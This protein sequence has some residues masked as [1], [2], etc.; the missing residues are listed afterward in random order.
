MIWRV[1]VD[2]GGT[3]TDVCLFEEGSG[4]VE[5]W[6]V[7]STPDDPSR[8]I[9]RGI[10]EAIERIGVSASEIG[11]LGH[12]TT[13]ATN[14]L[15]QHR[16]ASTGLITTDGFRD[17]LEI[18]R[19]KR[20]EL[21]DLQA[22]KP[23][24]LIS[25]DLRLQ[26]P[27]R[28]RHDGT[29]E[30]PLDEEAMRCAAR[31]LKAAG[32]KAVVVCFLYGFVRSEHEEIACRIVRD[33][34]PEAF[35][36]AGH[37]VAP[38]FREFERLSTAVV[39][40]YLGPVME[41]YI[42][43][44]AER[45]RELGIMVAPHLTQSNG[46]VI[47]LEP[48]ARL[49]VRTI[50][51]GPS[52]G[53]I[54]A[55]LIAR[56]A[57]IDNLI[58]FDMGG[59][60]TDV[61]LITGGEYRRASEA[62][63][64]GYPIK[65][66]MID[67]HTV[68]AGG[69]SIAYVDSGGLLKVGPRSA[70]AD[71]GPACYDRGNDEATVTDANLI[72]QTLNPLSLLGGRMKVRKDL[73]EAAI[74][75]LANK[76]GMDALSTADG[77]LSVVTANMGKAI[78]VISVQRG[79]DPRDYSLL[80]FG[81]AGPLH[82][83]R[84][85]KALDIKRIIIPRNPGI[86]CAIGLLL[87]DLRVEFAATQLTPLKPGTEAVITEVF[88][89]LTMKASRWFRTE[90]IAP[91]AQHISCSI[92]MRYAGQNYELQIPVPPGGFSLATIDDLGQGFRAAHERLYGFAPE[93]EPMQLVTFRLEAAGTRTQGRIST[94]ARCWFG[95]RAGSNRRARSLV[96]REPALC[97]SCHLRSGQA[98]RRQRLDW[99]CGG[100]ADGLHDHCR[101]RYDRPRRALPQSDP[102]N[103]M[104]KPPL[105]RIASLPQ[106]HID[107]I[108]V[109]VI[110]SA[111]SSTTEEMGEALVRA[112]YSTNIKER[113]DCSTAIFDLRGN[114]LCQAEHIPMHLGSF[115]EFIPHIMKR[116]AY[117]EIIPG[118]VFVGND[119]YEG[120]GTHLQDIVLAEP[121]FVEGRMIGW[122]INT[123][124]HADFADR[125]HAHIFQEGLRIP[126][127]RLY[128]AGQLQKDVQELI[129][130]NCQ[131]PDE[132]ISDF[133]AQMAANRLGVQ[134]MM[135]LCKK[136][137]TD[138]VLSAGDALQD[139]AERKMRAG[140]SAIPDGTYRFTDQFETSEIAP[141]IM[142]LSCEITVR[143]DEMDLR[144]ESPPQVRA[145]LNV[146]RT[147]L[148]STVYYAVKTVVDPTILPN[149]GLARPLTVDAPPR[150]VLNCGLPA[151]VYGRVTTCQRIVDLIHGALAQAVPER[152]IAATN[153]SCYS[154]TFV[155]VNPQDGSNWVY[156]ETI[157]G[158]SGAR[159]G[160]DGLDG[161]HVHLTNTSN[162]PVES[163]ELEY[164]LTL[165]RYELVDGSGG[166]GQFRGGMGLRRVYRAEADCRVRLI[167]SRMATSP[168]GL[169]GGLAGGR[170]G[171][172][173][174]P[175]TAELQRGIGDLKRGDIV[176]IITPGAG[177]YGP[178]Q[179]RNRASVTR[180]IAEGRIDCETAH[181]IYKD[182]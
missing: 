178:P 103:G 114:T 120:G 122:V 132:R 42:R 105:A 158:G 116:N 180:D 9:A 133:R 89:K 151:A 52:T 53:V 107:P 137:G 117:G 163:L 54:G 82:A 164:P 57:L 19:Q 64:H 75:K 74:S 67:I 159:A 40:A 129:L 101:T 110:G 111:L 144:F 148:L 160:K 33:E 166:A 96:C 68:G 14:A 161:V 86:L 124:H 30:I 36:S 119:A 91:E 165:L 156:L 121:I 22:D 141:L 2:S 143:G 35:V 97:G 77:I 176:E 5:V 12:G 155:G 58:T 76:L 109:E 72:L 181:R 179:L 21:Y 4:R 95:S 51:S 60:S 69:G 170:G 90:K 123:A 130:L 56:Q 16:G 142:D 71:P 152:V 162:L 8:A 47:G 154:A 27:E 136:Y 131:V 65:A 66:P 135:A 61:A 168:W 157:G 3:F 115:L 7:S 175:G 182:S 18:G 87:T 17:L 25:R 15:I 11:Y 153:G 13:V 49:P 127:I 43:R 46:G 99:T 139:Y 167:G 140:I 113:R 150:S 102:G 79:Y 98:T 134:R 104:M 138:V 174:S 88:Q 55:Q 171:F 177:G 48:A 41:A 92:D 94:S 20:P 45:S 146:V 173:V 100:R 31:Q 85:A 29:V 62:V 32:V 63:V 128:R 50:L 83:S 78:R 112:S 147:A 108:T 24:V 93:T 70:G 39:N 6:K 10:A 106:A 126:P 37:E 125:G 34:F 84:L 1:G 145:G 169:R 44:L 149:A 59:T 73:A 26:I 23:P 80:A 172:R 38:E 118:D 81:G 28:V